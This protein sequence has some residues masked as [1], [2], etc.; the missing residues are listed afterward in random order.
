[1]YV[2]TYR[3]GMRDSRHSYKAHSSRLQ[4]P[5]KEDSHGAMG[6]PQNLRNGGTV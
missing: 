6:I 2:F 3:K 4:S 5:E 1:M